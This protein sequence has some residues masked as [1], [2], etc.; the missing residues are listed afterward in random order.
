MH[1]LAASAA[2]TVPPDELTTGEVHVRD[3]AE[4]LEARTVFTIDGLERE[5]ALL[6]DARKVEL[7][8]RLADGEEAVCRAVLPSAE[9][10]RALLTRSWAGTQA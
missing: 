7:P 9:R 2:L 3:D 8:E 4:Q 1:R 10:I 5:L 6:A